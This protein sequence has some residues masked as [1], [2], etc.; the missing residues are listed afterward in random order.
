MKSILQSLANFIKENT[1]F[2]LI[3]ILIILF[4]GWLALIFVALLPQVLKDPAKID[5]MMTLLAGLGIGGISQ[6][7]MLLLKDGWQFF[8]RKKK[9]TETPK[10]TQ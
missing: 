1:Q 7:F 6:F 5:P 2:A 9:P 8:F 10:P 4:G 3:V